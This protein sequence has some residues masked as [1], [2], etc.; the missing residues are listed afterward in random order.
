MKVPAHNAVYD[1]RPV[2]NNIDV[3]NFVLDVDTWS[4]PPPPQRILRNFAVQET[5]NFAVSL[6]IPET[7][8][9]K[10]HLQI[11]SPG[12]FFDRQYWNVTVDAAQYSYVNAALEAGYSV[13]AYDRLSRGESDKPDPYTIT[14]T[15]LE[16]EI[17]RGTTE[18]AKER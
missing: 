7:G 2:N 14:Q 15:P 4:S 11:L 13:L 8:R 6:F 1:I 9:K 17:L 10:N 12:F 5:F 16:L 3:V 18:M